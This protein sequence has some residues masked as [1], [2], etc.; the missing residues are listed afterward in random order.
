MRGTPSIAPVVAARAIGWDE[1]E[2]TRPVGPGEVGGGFDVEGGCEGEV[3]AVVGVVVVAL[4]VEFLDGGLGLILR[5]ESEA[6]EG[7]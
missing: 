4:V 6:G 1:G 7:G 5:L 3:A 2:G